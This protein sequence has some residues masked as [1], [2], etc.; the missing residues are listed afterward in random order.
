MR[1]GKSILILS[2]L[3]AI[4]SVVGASTAQAINPATITVTVT[5][6]N[7][8]VAATGPIAFGTVATGSITASTDS[9]EVTNDG[10][11]SETYSLDVSEPA[12][13]TAV[14]AAT[15][16]D[17][18]CLHAQFNSTPPTPASF[19]YANHALTT[20]SVAASG[21]KF[22]GDQ[23]GESVAASGVVYLWL[24]FEAPATSTLFT[25]QSI[26]VTITAA[27]G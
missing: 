16:V 20:S 25:Q 4:G 3:L 7:L 22:A 12:G 8:S 9:S 2:A 23:D 18:F 15:G 17:Q 5:I 26:T 27:A 19:T 10:N 6:Q 24:K 14:Q 13:W 11:I 21:T 1:H